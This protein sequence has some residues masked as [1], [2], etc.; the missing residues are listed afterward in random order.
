MSIH[1][2]TG[3][4][5]KAVFASFILAKEMDRFAPCVI[6]TEWESLPPHLR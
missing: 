3:A 2:Y 4:L 6:N 5:K 1:S